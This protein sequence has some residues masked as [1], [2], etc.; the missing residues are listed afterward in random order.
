MVA[1]R[2]DEGRKSILA[3]HEQKKNEYTW[4]NRER[5]LDF[6]FNMWC[7]RNKTIIVIGC[8]VAVIFIC[9]WQCFS[10]KVIYN[11]AQEWVSSKNGDTYYLRWRGEQ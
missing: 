6:R 7:R 4:L 8:I 10:T 11:N 1:Y 5:F 2:T 9:V 3:R